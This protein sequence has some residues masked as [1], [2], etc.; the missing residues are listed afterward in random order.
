MS[1]LYDI[2]NEYAEILS[3]CCNE[4]GLSEE[5]IDKLENIDE[6]FN[7]KANNVALV[8]EELKADCGKINNEIDRLNSRL[9]VK[10]K[11]LRRLEAYLKDKMIYI[12]KNKVETP[13]HTISIRKSVKTEV[14]DQFIDWAIENQKENFINKKVTYTPNRMLIREEIE[15][16]NLECPY[17]QL[18]ENQNLIIK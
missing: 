18:V 6:T 5:L 12:G 3:N 14:S 15:K 9:A 16:G 8:I 7:E 13:I 4:D 17:A 11:N 2:A 10:V 1:T